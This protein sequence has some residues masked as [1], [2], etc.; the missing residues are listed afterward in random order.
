VANFGTGSKVVSAAFA[1]NSDNNFI[2]FA[3]DCTVMN[4]SPQKY[5]AVPDCTFD[6]YGIFMPDDNSVRSPAAGQLRTSL[7]AFA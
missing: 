2:A 7:S 3:A 1:H 5:P 6:S 4:F